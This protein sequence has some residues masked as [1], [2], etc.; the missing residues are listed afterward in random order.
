VAVAI[1]VPAMAI[2]V[3][4]SAGG[5]P[6]HANRAAAPADRYLVTEYFPV[7]ESWFHGRRVAARGLPGRH[8]QDFLWSPTGLSMEFDG[9]LRDGRRVHFA[10][11]EGVGW[12]NRNGYSTRP[13]P[14]GEWSNGPPVW[15]DVGWRNSDGQ[16]TF[17]LV[18]GGWSNRRGVSFEPSA[19]R[20]ATGPSEP[21][22]RYWHTAAVDPAVIPLGSRLYI[23]HFRN[24][25]NHGWFVAQ[26]VGHTIIDRQIDLFLPPPRSPDPGLQFSGR[27]KVEVFPPVSR[28]VTPARPAGG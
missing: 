24:A 25:P 13:R 20:Y 3:G 21:F 5:N 12:V 18:R 23:P 8:A 11:D 2:V 19:L 6:A 26:D 17:P 27:L 1:G 14:N 28:P 22:L 16:P 7:P 9:I 4:G 15:R 10:N